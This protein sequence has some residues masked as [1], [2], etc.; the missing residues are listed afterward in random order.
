MKSFSRKIKNLE[1]R[2]IISRKPHPAIPFVLF[3]IILILGI[4]TPY[5]NFSYAL[6]A[7]S[8]FTLVF[9]ILHLIVVRILEG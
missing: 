5:E 6:F 3:F 1:K 7:L 4:I 8:G 9:A 2:R